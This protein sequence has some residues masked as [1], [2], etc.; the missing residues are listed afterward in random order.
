[1][2]VAAV[3]LCAVGAVVWSQVAADEPALD[4]VLDEPGVYFEPGASNPPPATDALPA[5]TLEDA[6]GVP[7]E[8]AT[9][10]RPM[11]V[12]LW[13]ST[14]PPCA[15]E[16]ADLATVHGEVGERV[17]FVGVDPLDSTAEM[18]R[19]AS[20]RGVTYELLRDPD[21]LLAAAL[22]VVAYPVTLFVDPDGAIAATSGPIDADELRRRL[23]ELWP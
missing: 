13:F 18:T 4:A 7:V 1:V 22:D 11:I 12:N 3:G 15:R 8:L 20:R 16:L 17:R 10:G 5:V 14:C 9:D 23:A 19:F 21:G 6:T 2:L